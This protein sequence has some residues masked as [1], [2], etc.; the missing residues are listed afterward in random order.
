MTGSMETTIK[1]NYE[2]TTLKRTL[3]V[4]PEV[5]MMGT[6]EYDNLL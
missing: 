2:T 5:S 4:E 1:T 6:N 3:S